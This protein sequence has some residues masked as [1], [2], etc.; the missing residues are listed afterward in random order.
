MRARAV[1]MLAALGV[2]A[3]LALPVGAVAKPGHYTTAGLSTEQFQL[4]GSN[5]YSLRV[6]VVDRSA[7]LIFDKR[8]GHSF[9]TVAYFMRGKLAPGPDL[10]FPIGNEG[11]VNLRFVPRGRPEETTLPGCKGGPQITEKGGLVGTVR[12][13]G[14]GGFTKI[15]THRAHVIVFRAPPMTC[16]K[17]KTPNN[18]LTVGLPASGNEVPEEFVQ[19]IAGSVP[20]SPTFDADLFEENGVGIDGQELPDFPDFSASISRREGGAE[21]S[22]AASMTGRPSSFGVPESLDPPATATV[23]PAAPFSGSATFS[24]TSPHHAKWSGD[25]AVVLPGYG[26]VPLTG[27]KIRAGLCR[28]K[29]CTPTLPRSLRPA[30]G[31]ERDGLDG[32]YYTEGRA[33]R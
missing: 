31:S 32:S 33:A 9:L 11:E 14:K 16:R 5:G 24:L 23:E 4:R 25:L 19:L 18:I 30:T 17:P 3:A 27:P 13:R 26:R 7:Q 1:A 22:Y 8:V 20:G 28:G 29:T 10:R 15:D 21:V 6:A 12:F 2:L